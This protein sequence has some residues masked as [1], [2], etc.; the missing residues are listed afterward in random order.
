MIYSHRGIYPFR[1]EI[2]TERLRETKIKLHRVKVL[3]PSKITVN[4]T[5]TVLAPEWNATKK[6][7]VT[8]L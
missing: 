7:S 5:F 6:N 3:C 8:P 4:F 2:L 1:F